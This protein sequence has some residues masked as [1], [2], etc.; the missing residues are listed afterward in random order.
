M[1][2]VMISQPMNN[3]T[4]EEII[5]ERERAEKYLVSK[6]H[7]ALS[8]DYYVEWLDKSY[9]RVP[10]ASVGDVLKNM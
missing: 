10:L 3:K 4:K 6:V 7:R 5:E 9:G 8:N 2:K 1:K